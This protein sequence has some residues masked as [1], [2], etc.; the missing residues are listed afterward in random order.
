MRLKYERMIEELKRSQ[1]N[2]KEFLQKEMLRKIDELERQI[3]D[4]KEKFEREK[5]QLLKEKKEM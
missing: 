1:M 3:K 5:E 4:L 2:D